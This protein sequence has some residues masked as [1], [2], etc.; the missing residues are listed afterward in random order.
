M[1]DGGQQEVKNTDVDGLQ[2]SCVDNVH[3]RP[4][5]R[6]LNYACVHVSQLLRDPSHQSDD[7]APS[8]VQ[9]HVLDLA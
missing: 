9:S 5:P 1:H 6:S 8:V 7:W 2:V 3:D 4:D